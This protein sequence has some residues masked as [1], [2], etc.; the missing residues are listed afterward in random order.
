MSLNFLRFAEIV[1]REYL[2]SFGDGVKYQLCK[3]KNKAV[4]DLLQMTVKIFSGFPEKTVQE[5]RNQL[6]KFL[7]T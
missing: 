6:V 3:L 7:I 2:F 5:F 1:P 4:N